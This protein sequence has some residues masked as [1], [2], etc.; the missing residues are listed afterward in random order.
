MGLLSVAAK[1]M[2]AVGF[3]PTRSKTLRPE[4]NPLDH[5]GKLTAYS[6][7]NTHQ[8]TRARETPLHSY[9]PHTP[10]T[11][12]QRHASRNASCHAAACVARHDTPSRRQEVRLH[13]AEAHAASIHHRDSSA[14]PRLVDG[15]SR[16]P[17]G[18][19]APPFDESGLV[20]T[21]ATDTAPPIARRETKEH[22]NALRQRDRADGGSAK[23]S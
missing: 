6:T 4:R 17:H 19:E 2:S 10:H 8:T 23:R 11:S 9:T 15:L 20:L 16:Q 3:E 14:S 18:T 21:A 5:S 12:R 13:H 22:M 1:E 7:T